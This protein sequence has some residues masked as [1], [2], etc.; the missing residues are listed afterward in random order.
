M[1]EGRRRRPRG[2]PGTAGSQQCV[3]HRPLS[4]GRVQG[5]R[6]CGAKKH[7]GSC[8]L[9]GG[10]S[11]NPPTSLLQPREG[12]PRGRGVVNAPKPSSKP[13]RKIRARDAVE[14]GCRTAWL[15]THLS[16]QFCGP[17]ASLRPAL[18][19]CNEPRRRPAAAEAASARTTSVWTND[20]LTPYSLTISARLTGTPVL[21]R[22]W[23][24]AWAP[25][26]SPRRRGAMRLAGAYVAAR[27]VPV[28]RR[29]GV[30]T[31]LA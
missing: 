1:V 8:D 11:T 4:S 30:D 27:N 9:A 25:T 31:R 19:R 20:A 3:C 7:S 16:H 21:R 15:S 10:D 2:D 24:S 23:I 18:G 13:S 12:L 26:V 22:R 28:C 29:F 17:P 14:A 5:R 6:R